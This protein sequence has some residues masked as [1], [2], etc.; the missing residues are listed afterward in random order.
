MKEALQINAYETHLFIAAIVSGKKSPES[1]H[2]DGFINRRNNSN[3]VSK[4]NLNNV[5]V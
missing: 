5:E 2:F 3:N 4:S 1:E